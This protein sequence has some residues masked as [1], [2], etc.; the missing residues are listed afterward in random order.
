MTLTRDPRMSV[1]VRG[2]RR[3]LPEGTDLN[4]HAS[5]LGFPFALLCIVALV[6]PAAA[7]P[8]VEGVEAVFERYRSSALA[9]N[10]RTALDTVSRGTITLYE[11]CRRL[12]IDAKESELERLTQGEVLV[13]LRM[14]YALEREALAKM[15]GRSCFQHAMENGWVSDSALEKMRLG[16]VRYDGDKAYAT[17]LNDGQAVEGMGFDFVKEKGE[18]RFDVNGLFHRAEPLF[19]QMRRNEKKNKVALGMKFLERVYGE[20]IPREILAG[21]LE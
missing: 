10:G 8:D 7:D 1:D 2:S 9:R 18:W 17:V 13:V 6:T 14:R 21:P 4:T 11:N 12:A 20:E 5:R 16:T 3:G 19:A 15:D